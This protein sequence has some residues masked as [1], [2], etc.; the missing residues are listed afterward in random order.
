MRVSDLGSPK[1]G[2]TGGGH[3]DPVP[4]KGFLCGEALNGIPP[5]ESLI[6]QLEGFP[7]WSPIAGVPTRLCSRWVSMRMSLWG[8]FC[9]NPLGENHE[10][11]QLRGHPSGDIPWKNLLG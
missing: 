2:S 10:G 5:S 8:P 9:W 7:G 4:L 1:K 6:G 3:F 11:S